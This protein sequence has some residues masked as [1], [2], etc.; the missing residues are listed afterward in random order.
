MGGGEDLQ[1]I[2]F[3]PLLQPSCEVDVIFAVDSS[4]DTLDPAGPNWPNGTAMVATYERSIF[5]D[6][7]TTFPPVPDVNTF[8]NL[9]LNSRPTMFG[10]DAGNLTANST[11]PLVVYLPH[12]PYVF[13]SNV[14]TFTPSYAVDER[15]AI[16]RNGYNVVTRG[17]G[18]VDSQWP[19]CVACA[20]MS[21]SWDRTNTTVPDVCKDCFAKYCWDGTRNDTVPGPYTP[22]MLLDALTV[23]GAA[24][25]QRPMVGLP[26]FVVTLTFVVLGL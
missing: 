19:T 12:S 14:L 17:N 18:T 8:I 24:G 16:I 3:T 5:Q 9:G 1:N 26:F 7:G 15:N 25:Q 2:P 22:Q 4:A 20:I 13:N 21:R 11:A 23:E 6:D 10:C